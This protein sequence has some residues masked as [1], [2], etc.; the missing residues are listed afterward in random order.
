ME[1]ALER[2]KLGSIIESSSKLLDPLVQDQSKKLDELLNQY[3]NLMNSK[4]TSSNIDG[5]FF[6]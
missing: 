3:D 1:I 6:N 4:K 2:K 5:V